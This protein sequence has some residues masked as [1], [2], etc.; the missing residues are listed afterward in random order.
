[1]ENEIAIFEQENIVVFEQLSKFKA[2]QKEMKEKEDALK[3]A[4]EKSMDEH[5]I[6]SFKNEYVTITRVEGSTTTTIDVDGMKE[7]EPELYDEL[8]ADYPKVK[9]TKPYVRI[10]VK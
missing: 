4:L 1:M 3:K 6:K 2:M 5:G 7:K 10:L 9:T 8:I